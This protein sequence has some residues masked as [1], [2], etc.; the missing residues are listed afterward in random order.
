MT[1]A[2][3]GD[4][5]VAGAP[6]HRLAAGFLFSATPML[7]VDA[8]GRVEEINLA[9]SELTGRDLAGAVGSGLEV[10]AERLRPRA[11]GL[12]L[13]AGLA[14]P[15]GPVW[16]PTY[17][18]IHVGEAEFEYDS[19]DH[20]PARLGVLAVP[21]IDA[22]DG[23]YLG[24]TV[25]FVVR[26]IGDPGRF[27]E[28]LRRRWSREIMW[29]IYAA[30]YDR[31]LKQMPFYREVVE[32]HLAALRG[33]DA[34]RI[35]DLGAGTGNVAVPLLEEGREVVAVDLSRA[36]TARLRDKAPA[37]AAGRLAVILD[38]AERLPQLAD[39]SFDGVSALL[40]LFDMD[41]P[42]SALSE[43]IRMLRPGGV[44]VVTDPKACFDVRPL[45]E[46]AERHLRDTGLLPELADDWSRVASVAPG[47]ES[48]IRGDKDRSAGRAGP[49][50]AESILAILQDQGFAG[51]TFRDSHL[52]QCATIVG[53]KPRGPEEG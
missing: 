46:L 3:D 37:Q 27:V 43:A 36:M 26:R 52:G 23:G 19:P 40:S 50:N 39:A 5:V 22:A 47:L 34:G 32:R 44:L 1:L 17:D 7:V 18:Q 9:L 29:I 49:W 31:I 16:R 48:R 33:A 21:S 38:T 24:A 30:S 51:L 11:S 12:L 45:L 53:R 14:N 42:R 8:Q 10:I 28:A 6:T 41:E 35:L 13:P 2:R 15:P 4:G 25:S 20:G